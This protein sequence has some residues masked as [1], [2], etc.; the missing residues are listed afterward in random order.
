MVGVGRGGAVS[1]RHPS[2]DTLTSA[3]DLLRSIGGDPET[4]KLVETMAAERK[5]LDE[6]RAA[7]DQAAQEAE[8]RRDSAQTAEAK[9]VEQRQAL[10][11]ERAAFETAQREATQR[12]S[13]VR[14]ELDAKRTR[15]EAQAEAV[16]QLDRKVRGAAEALRDYLAGDA[17]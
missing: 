13:D 10:A 5:A 17:A 8:N 14:A 12:E 15:V 6:A 4:K 7:H 2:Q 1:S 11:D 3:L 16:A 9:A